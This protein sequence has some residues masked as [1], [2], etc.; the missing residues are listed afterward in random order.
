M[1]YRAAAGWQGTT[2]QQAQA[3]HGHSSKCAAVLL[4]LQLHRNYTNVLVRL[5]CSEK[6]EGSAGFSAGGRV[7]SLVPCDPSP[8]RLHLRAV[9]ARMRGYIRF[10]TV[11]KGG[12]RYLARSGSAGVRI[13]AFYSVRVQFRSTKH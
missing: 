13:T 11:S 8:A 3:Q 12:A 1:S 2:R 7:T 5:N 6:E 10:M 4:R 9:T